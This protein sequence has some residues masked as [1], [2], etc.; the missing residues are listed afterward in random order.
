MK[1]D[2]RLRDRY[3]QGDIFDK[4]VVI[5][6]WDKWISVPPN[7]INGEY[8]DTWTDA[9]QKATRKVHT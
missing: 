4:A 3:D 1:R 7:R 2:L 8:F 5:K 9:F 6:L